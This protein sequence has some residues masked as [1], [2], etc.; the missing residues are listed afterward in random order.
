MK[1]RKPQ[2]DF[3]GTTP[4]WAPRWE[5]ALFL[6]AQSMLFPPLE[7]FLNRVML[8]ARQEVSGTDPRSQQLRRDIDLF[9]QQEGVHFA[10]HAR[11]NE[12]LERAGFAELPEMEA[13]M[14]EEYRGFLKTKSL[15]FLSAYCEG[16]EIL[17][18]IF[19]RIHLDQLE[20]YY[21]GSDPNVVAMWKWHLMEEYEHRTV[22]FDVYEHLFGGYLPRIRGLI[23]AHRHMGAY[24]RRVAACMLQRECADTD[25]LERAAAKARLK[26]IQKHVGSLALRH[27][28]RVFSPFYTPRAAAPPISLQPFEREL[29][30][31]FMLSATR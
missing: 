8:M 29:D 14:D 10:V 13:A 6:N 23:F 15:R 24:I 31:D 9:V 30:R 4:C 7:R 11:F 20:E 2:F 12:M 17:G 26:A 21:A 16:F 27:V 28:I 18:P 19:A 5:F 3:S 22:C 25:E 1:L